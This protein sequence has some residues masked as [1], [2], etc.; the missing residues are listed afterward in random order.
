MSDD[1][2]LRKKYETNELKGKVRAQALRKWEDYLGFAA[3]KITGVGA[4]ISGG[5]EFVD[6]N[7]LPIIMAEPTTA[8]GV[9]LGLLVGRKAVDV[10][11]RALDA[12]KAGN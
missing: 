11:S 2:A 6:P 3:S 12:I 4:L 7:I 5:L 10:A 9:G 1:E 8:I